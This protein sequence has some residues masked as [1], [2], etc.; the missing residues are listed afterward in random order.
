MR[1]FVEGVGLLGP[2]LNGWDASRAIL[3]GDAAYIESPTVVTPSPLLPPAERRR[4]GVPVKLALAV[5]HQAFTGAGRDAAATATV[6]TSSG[7]DSDNVHEICQTLATSEREVSPT[8]FHN[9]VH[10]AAAGYWSIAMRSREPSTSLCGFD[11]SFPAGLLEAT[12]QIAVDARPV[13]LIAYDQPYPEPLRAVRPLAANFAVALVL[14]PHATSRTFAT[15]DVSFV[16]A[17][18]IGTP[19][20]V[21]ALECLRS[22][23][24]AAR[25]LPLFVAL[26]AGATEEIVV[27]WGAGSHIKIAVAPC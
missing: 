17:P 5:G 7:G 20:R 21:A 25:A 3:T 2:G 15:L 11:A 19:M 8:R 23:V 13:A 6:F 26:A 14:A 1:V 18:G 12:V 27:E 4:T 22:N 9:S 10:N 16:A 24:P